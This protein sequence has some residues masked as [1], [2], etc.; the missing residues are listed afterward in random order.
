LA[1]DQAIPR[2]PSLNVVS[3]AVPVSLSPRP[4]VFLDVVGIGSPLLDIV[5]RADDGLLERLGLPKGSMT[6]VDRDAAE[7]IYASMGTTIQVSGGSA[8]NTVAGIASLG[9]TAGFVG[10]IADDEIGALFSHDIIAIG[11][12]FEAAVVPATH[13]GSG[14]CLVIVTPDAQ[15]TMATHLGVANGF[16]PSDLD[17]SIIERS[18]ITYLEG[19]LFDQDPAKAAMRA[20]VTAA[21]E[22]EGSVA[23]SL[24]DS[25]CVERHRADFLTLIEEE[26]ELLFA[27][28]DEIRELFGAGSTKAALD[29]IEEIGI[30]A[31]VTLGARGC[32]VVTPSGRI[33]VP[34]VAVS[35]VVDTNGAGDLFAAGFLYGMTHNFDPGRSGELGALCAS[36]VIGH[37]GARPQRNLRELALEVGLLE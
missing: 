28:E 29:A 11:V 12:E 33:E 23:V 20:A 6:L 3:N 8:A 24:S 13:E 31:A 27:N 35:D 1:S 14:R 2:G 22:A 30:V 25:F 34:A 19:Y 16:A 26:A 18:Q 15:R 36:E 17:T 4:P 21:H 5:A 32:V 7:A 9:G 10:R 37:L